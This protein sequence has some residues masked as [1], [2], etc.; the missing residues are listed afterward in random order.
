MPRYGRADREE[1]HDFIASHCTDALQ[2]PSKIPENG[3]KR[4]T[5]RGTIV[6]HYHHYEHRSPYD[7]ER[8]HLTGVRRRN[9]V[10]ARK[11]GRVAGDSID[12]RSISPRCCRFACRE[13]GFDRYLRRDF[14]AAGATSFPESY[15][16][17]IVDQR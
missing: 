7:L 2:G 13:K 9:D 10:S 8:H 12:N 1:M 4:M 15:R 11:A 5:D 6:D 14:H 3:E 16:H 17:R